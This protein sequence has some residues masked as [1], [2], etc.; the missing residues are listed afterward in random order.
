MGGYVLARLQR[1]PERASVRRALVDAQ[2]AD[3]GYPAD[4][5]YRTVP[6]PVTTWYGSRGLTTALVLQALRWLEG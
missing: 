4:P 1:L 2:E 5:F 6:H 3:G